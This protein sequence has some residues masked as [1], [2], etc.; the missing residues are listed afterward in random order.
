VKEQDFNRGISIMFDKDKERIAK[1]LGVIQDDLN[2]AMTYMSEK[3]NKVA[4]DIIK[5]QSAR[6]LGL[7]EGLGFDATELYEEEK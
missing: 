7:A 6:L 3:D 1:I 4:L 5:F 2:R